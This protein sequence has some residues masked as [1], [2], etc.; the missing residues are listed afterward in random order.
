MG[1][2]VISVQNVR[3]VRSVSRESHAAQE[4][5]GATARAEEGLVNP[6]FISH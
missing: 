5:C 4:K 6:A 3:A 1:S 2:D